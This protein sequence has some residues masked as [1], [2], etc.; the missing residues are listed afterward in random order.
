LEKLSQ[1]DAG[2]RNPLSD[3][4]K[5]FSPPVHITLRLVKTFVKAMKKNGRVV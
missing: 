3:Y 4:A 1:N 2:E 5:V